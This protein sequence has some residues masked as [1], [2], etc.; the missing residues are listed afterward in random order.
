MRATDVFVGT[1]IQEIGDAV[2]GANAMLS[3]NQLKIAQVDLEFVATLSTTSGI[4]LKV[5]NL[6]ISGSGSRADAQTI[7]LTLVPRK[8]LR[9]AEKAVAD[10]LATA[11]ATLVRAMQLATKGLPK[12]VPESSTVAVNLGIDAAGKASLILAGSVKKAYSGEAKFKIVP[13]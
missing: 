6:G 4:E 1:F 13:A 11:I 2:E 10:Q 5:A 7:S 9:D 3:A 8:K 12:Y